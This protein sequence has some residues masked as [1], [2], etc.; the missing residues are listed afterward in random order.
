MPKYKKINKN[1]LLQNIIYLQIKKYNDHLLEELKNKCVLNEKEMEKFK[2]IFEIRMN[3]NIYTDLNKL[4][5]E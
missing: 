2:R 4:E 1:N 3:L 5:F